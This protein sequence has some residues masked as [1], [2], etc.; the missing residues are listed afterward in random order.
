MPVPTWGRARSEQPDVAF[1]LVGNV[2]A[3]IGSKRPQGLVGA[4]ELLGVAIALVLDQGE[5]ADRP[6]GLTQLDAGSLGQPRRAVSW[7]PI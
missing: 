3:E 2:A 1:E 6:V 7:S 5:F 4:L